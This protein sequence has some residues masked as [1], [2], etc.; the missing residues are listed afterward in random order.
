MKDV[1]SVL[2]IFLMCAGHVPYIRN[3]MRG[4]TKPHIYSWFIWCLV[5][6]IAAAL[7][8]VGGGGPGAWVTMIAALI[9]AATFVLSIPYGKNNITKH[10]TILLCLA[11]VALGVWLFAKQPVLSVLLVTI[12]DMLGLIPTIRKSW[13]RPHE[14]TLKTYAMNVLRIS[15]ALLALQQYSVLTVL[16]PATWALASAMFS[17]F[18]WA[19]R[20]QLDSDMVSTT[21][22]VRDA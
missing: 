17:I 8:F 21:T 14:E 18:L 19:R 15:L 11:L 9:C 7:Q 2:A 16:Y 12:I 10:D 20:M 3:I 13:R 22:E 6:S 5:T 1:L 4:K